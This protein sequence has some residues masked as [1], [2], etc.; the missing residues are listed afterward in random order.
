MTIVDVRSG[1]LVPG[2]DIVLEGGRIAA[3]VA[4]TSGT[5]G[6]FVV[7]GFHDMH[8]HPLEL[9]DPSGALRLMLAHG[10][11]GVRQMSGS[12]RMLR[13]RARGTLPLPDESPEIVAM[14]GSVLTPLNAG[15]PKAAVAAVAAQQDA[16]ADFIKVGLVPAEAL[17]AAQAEAARRGI[18]ILGHLPLDVDVRRASRNGM[19]SIEHLG[20]GLGIL[21]ACST[22]EQSIRAALAAKRMPRLPSLRLP[23]MDQIVAA[24]VRRMAVNPTKLSKAADLALTQRAIDTFATDKAAALASQFAADGTWQCPTLI[25]KRTTQLCDDPAYRNDPELR[26]VAPPLVERWNAEADAF[27]ARPEQERATFRAEYALQL[28]VTRMF[29]R[30]G[31]RMLAGSD[32]CG[33]VWQIAGHSLHQE[34]DELALAGLSPL[35]ILQMTTI[36]AA[37]FLGRSSTA[38]TVEAGKNADLVLLDA[39]PLADAEHLHRISGVVRAGRLHSPADLRDR[40]AA[41]QNVG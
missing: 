26:Y 30:A 32:A 9:P 15:S 23:F 1:A 11:T 35:R 22:D 6:T 7:P 40:V 2:R 41:D 33:A 8:A 5:S 28:R 10:I 4:S 31:V 39:D 27:A 17:Y 3:I 20:P 24:L 36:D 18:P 21:G 34:F 19:R 12:D 38:G 37:E 25:R 16:G 29:D 14:P 13:Q